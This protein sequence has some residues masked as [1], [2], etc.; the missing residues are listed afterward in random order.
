MPK[1][2]GFVFPF[3]QLVCSFQATGRSSPLEKAHQAVQ[4]SAVLLL[5]REGIDVVGHWCC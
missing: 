2:L 4:G 3:A 5:V 1:R